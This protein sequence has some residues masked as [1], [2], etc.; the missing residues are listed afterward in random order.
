MA[1]TP[2]H[3]SFATTDKRVNSTKLV[4]MS[5]TL[6]CF[7]KEPT[8]LITPTILIHLE[9]NSPD[10]AEVFHWNYMYIEEFGRYYF[11][12][13]IVSESSKLVYISGTVDVL[14]TY[15][16]SVLNTRAFIQY[17][18]TK[19]NSM[20]HDQRLHVERNGHTKLVTPEEFNI[21]SNTGAYL[22]TI[23][24]ESGISETVVLDE[25]GMQALGSILWN[26]TL[27]G[28]LE[29]NMLS[30]LQLISS[31][32]WVPIKPNELKSGQTTSFKVKGHTYYEGLDKAKKTISGDTY[33]QL[34]TIIPWK[35]TTYQP[36][37]IEDYSTYLNIEPFTQLKSML[38]GVG[39]VQLP[40]D[41]IMGNGNQSDYDN[42]K[43]H[44]EISGTTGEISYEIKKTSGYTGSSQYDLPLI[45]AQGSLGVP[46]QLSSSATNQAGALASAAKAAI[47]AGVASW[48]G[49][50]K[51]G[52]SAINE[53]IESVLQANSVQNSIAG[54]M[55]GFENAY[56]NKEIVFILEYYNPSDFASNYRDTIGL[57]YFRADE[58]SEH[59]GGVIKCTGAWVQAEGAT[60]P[61]NQQIAQLVNSSANFIF[62]GLIVE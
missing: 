24:S 5:E 44:Y 1:G 42:I 58:I 40:L 55:G 9:H 13:N 36:P 46:I 16:E 12:T 29:T 21:M 52:V 32:V 62:G 3:V 48:T 11:I 37:I 8:S 34:T 22:V 18:A 17:S 53:G 31:C 60:E 56:Y 10:Y 7:L 39:I 51:A 41:Q 4:D 14:A 2:A 6:N 61:E 59:M 49:S 19:G 26:N 45:M 50:I 28:D 47:S 15:R 54:Y 35:F 30:P 33:V 25:S 38:P 20:L 23:G 57:P 27:L 43:V